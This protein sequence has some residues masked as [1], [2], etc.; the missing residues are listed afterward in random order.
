M[1]RANKTG[2]GAVF[3]SLAPFV[4]ESYFVRRKICGADWFMEDGSC[5]GKPALRRGGFKIEKFCE[6]GSAASSERAEKCR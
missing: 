4:M 6:I 2:K 1:D 5:H 3:R